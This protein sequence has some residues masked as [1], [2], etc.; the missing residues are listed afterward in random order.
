MMRIVRSMGILLLVAASLKAI[1]GQDLP[2]DFDA[3]AEWWD[4]NRPGAR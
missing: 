2:E 3:W 1:T 4:K